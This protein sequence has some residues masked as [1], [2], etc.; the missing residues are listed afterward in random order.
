M[1]NYKKALILLNGIEK[2][3]LKIE[4]EY[5]KQKESIKSRTKDIQTLCDHEYVIG[6]LK[7]RFQGK[8]NCLICRKEFVMEEAPNFKFFVNFEDICKEN[9][10]IVVS[11]NDYSYLYN[12]LFDLLNAK[13]KELVNDAIDENELYE[14][15]VSLAKESISVYYSSL[16]LSKPKVRLLK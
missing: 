5:L 12:N 8:C 14:L 9:D 15:L 6:E 1:E 11:Y 4:R 2:E 7:N 3:N 13:L 10:I 16:L